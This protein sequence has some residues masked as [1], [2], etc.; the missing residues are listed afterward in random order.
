[1][2]DKFKSFIETNGLI[3]END[4]I[5]LAVSGGIDS[6][7]M[8]NLFLRTD[9]KFGIAHC[10]F[11]LRGIESDGDE[12]FVKDYAVKRDI[13]FY[14]KRF[15]TS[16]YAAKNGISI[17][18]AAR[19]LRYKWFDLT[20]QKHGYTSISL[21]HNLNDNIETFLINLARGTGINGLTGIKPLNNNLIRPLLFATRKSITDYSYEYEVPY[22][23]DSSNAETKYVRNKIRHLL[24]PILKDINPSIETTL[25]ETI[26]RVNEI[27]EIY[28]SSILEIKSKLTI[29]R[30]D[31]IAFRIE[32]LKKH[33]I[34][35]TILYELFKG[36]GI[37][38]MQLDDLITIINGRSGKQII[39]PT[40]RLIKNRKELLVTENA[41]DKNINYLINELSD[42]KNLPNVSEAFITDVST[43]YSEADG[44]ARGCFDAGKVIYPLKI[45]KWQKGD[46]FFPLGMKQKKKLSDYFIDNKLSLFEK[47]NCTILESDGKIMWIIGDRIDDRFKITNSTKNI[48]NIVF[49]KE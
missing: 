29:K 26:L 42:F 21:A 24:L 36:Y 16:K 38:S 31:H 13:P 11:N 46:T 7:V 22:R 23:E 2:I 41:P 49:S 9:F 35:K 20:L 17:Q 47:E 8:A 1:M 3:S 19:E 34:G 25:N 10:N 14:V 5:L 43:G 40:H 39:T 4:T 48:L 32:D 28:V 15:E 18:M 30:D 33:E 37:G 44:K 45:R 6:M 27:N 12:E